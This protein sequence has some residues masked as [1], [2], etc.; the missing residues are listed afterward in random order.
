[1]L[2]QPKE[3]EKGLFMKAW[4]ILT[5]RLST[6]AFLGLT[7]CA[8][9]QTMN[10]EFR[11][12]TL[13]ALRSGTINL[14][15]GASCA[16]G[17]V[18]ERERI[19]AFDAAGDWESLALR[20]AQVG[21]QK[22]LAYYYL[23][24]AAE[25]L[26]Y[27]EAALS[28][29][30]DSYTLA[31]GSQPGPQ[32][33]QVA[34]GCMGVDLLAV[35]PVKLKLNAGAAAPG[36]NRTAMKQGPN[37]D[38]AQSR[39]SALP[40]PLATPAR[41][42]SQDLSLTQKPLTPITRKIVDNLTMQLGQD[43]KHTDSWSLRG[44]RAEM[45]DPEFGSSM[46][47]YIRLRVYGDLNGDGVAD[48]V[49]LVNQE[50]PGNQ[51]SVYLVAVLAAN[52]TPHVTNP[53]FIDSPGHGVGVKSFQIRNGKIVLDS[54]QVGPNDAMCCP[55]KRVVLTYAIKNGKLVRVPN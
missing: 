38:S 54:L 50:G 42:G 16:W 26:G 46:S 6:L 5:A 8:P 15:C 34:G 30:G 14:N 12:Q 24:R 39:E 51:V 53:Q 47:A 55:T 43:E 4:G 40:A 13:S 28:Y 23:G 36:V 20:V 21:Y 32:C 9:V 19:R 25:G 11:A 29:F 33:R 27:R 3:N 7:A 37:A 44:G 49:V 31:T 18:N 41:D 35:L 1:V 48:A 52:G 17:W 22:D 45:E 2:N 10:P